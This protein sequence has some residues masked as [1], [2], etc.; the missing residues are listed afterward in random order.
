MSTVTN[1]PPATTM[2]DRIEAAYSRI[3][4]TSAHLGIVAMIL[5]GV[6]FDAIEQNTVGV[7]GPILAADWGL[8]GAQIGLLNTATFTAVALGRVLAGVVMDRIGRRT[9]L[10]ANLMIFAVGSLLCA[11]APSYEIL[12]AARFLVGLGLGGEI[13]TAVIMLAEFFS[14]KHRGTAVGLINVAAAGL[15]NMLAPLFGVIVFS[16]FTGDDRWRW[17][18]GIL[19]IPALAVVVY[20]RALPE[21]PRYLAAR[22]RVAEANTVINRLAQGRLHRPVTDEVDYLGGAADRPVTAVSTPRWTELFGRRHRRTTIALGVA[23][24][25]SYA[26]QISMLTLIPLILT[27]RG[28]DITSALWYTLVMQSGSL[29]GALVAALA[30]RR[31]PRKLTLTVAALLGIGAGLG[32]GFLGTTVALVLVFGFLFNF[33][34]IVLNTTI[35]LFAPEQYPTRIRGLGTSVILALGS[36]SGGLFPLLAGAVLDASGVGGMFALLA[37][38]FAICAIAVQ[39]P[40]ETVGRPMAED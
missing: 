7:A 16:V 23:V 20:R 27:S 5:F 24:C 37:G 33:S 26:A 30:A 3:G 1:P 4:V 2:G 31:L 36:L 29:V 35:W 19:V 15:G 6:F 14:A 21:T 13:A 40:R 22:G 17:L 8:A 11:F 38:L 18:F 32:F 28:F 34:V 9:L 25:M 12:V 39:F 10:G